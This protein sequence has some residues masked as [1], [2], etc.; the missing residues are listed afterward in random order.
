MESVPLFPIITASWVTLSILFTTAALWAAQSPSHGV[1]DVLIAISVVFSLY[2]ALLISRRVLLSRLRPIT[3]GLPTTDER[4]TRADVRSTAPPVVL[5]SARLRILKVCFILMPFI[6]VSLLISRAVDMHQETN[7]TMLQ[8]LYEANANLGGLI[9]I[10][11]LG[12][13]LF[14]G[15]L[16][17]R[18][19]WPGQELP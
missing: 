19:Q 6:L 1:R 14:F 7:Q 17:I 5:S 9:I 4:I 15:L 2:G 8:T 12:I 16:F 10:F 3:A 18:R 13:F 11:A